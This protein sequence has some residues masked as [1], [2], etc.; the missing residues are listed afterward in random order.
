MTVTVT[1]AAAVQ[2]V[3]MSGEAKIE[4]GVQTETEEE[5]TARDAEVP[6]KEMKEREHHPEK[7]VQRK[8]TMTSMSAKRLTSVKRASKTLSQL[9]TTKPVMIRIE[10]T[11][12]DRQLL[13]RLRSHSVSSRSLQV[14]LYS[15]DVNN[16]ATRV[17]GGSSAS[18]V[19]REMS[20]ATQL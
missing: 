19:G 12:P 6:K 9:E 5:E 17:M 16:V 2:T 3:Q 18:S 20:R 7:T 13:A 15:E 11:R 1:S 4:A 10:S 14:N 8:R